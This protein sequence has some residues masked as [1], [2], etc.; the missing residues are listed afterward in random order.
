MAGFS[1]GKYE[2]RELLPEINPLGKLV[3]GLQLEALFE[4]A[5]GSVILHMVSAEAGEYLEFE[6]APGSSILEYLDALVP[7]AGALMSCVQWSREQSESVGPPKTCVCDVK[8]IPCF[9]SQVLRR[10]VRKLTPL[11][12]LLTRRQCLRSVSP[13][14]PLVVGETARGPASRHI[15][16]IVC[17]VRSTK[18]QTLLNETSLYR[19][20]Y[21]SLR[22]TVTPRERKLWRVRLYLCADDNDQLFQRHA[23]Q[24]AADSPPGLETRLLFIP[25]RANRVPSREA[26][27]QAR[28]DGAEYFHRT[29]DDIGYLSAGWLT[30]S[31]RALRRLEPPNIGVAGPKVYGDGSSNKMHGGIT[32]DVALRALTPTLTSPAT[33]NPSPTPQP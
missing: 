18:V 4:E 24:V 30:A 14:M 13:A 29:N 20:L 33:P 31:V 26:A 10:L 7:A 19:T 17:C 11:Q 15:F 27:E 16:A 28:L 3:R 22:N 9:I 21:P 8:R 32:I 25:A 23:A 6:K 12:V 2:P 1:L 5:N